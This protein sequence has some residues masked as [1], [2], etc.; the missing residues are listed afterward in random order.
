MLPPDL[1]FG[2][3]CGRHLGSLN[4]DSPVEL[5]A[6]LGLAFS[7]MQEAAQPWPAPAALAS[8][9]SPRQQAEGWPAFRGAGR[10]LR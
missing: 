5:E 2:G 7:V 10:G 4:G 9:A 8:P 6:D 1:E 3:P